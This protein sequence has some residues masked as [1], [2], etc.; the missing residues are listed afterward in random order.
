MREIGR[1]IGVQLRGGDLVV[2][3]GGLGAGKT[4][5]A[6][7]IGSALGITNVTSPTFV[8]SRIHNGKI[9]LIHVDAYRLIPSKQRDFEFD[10]LDIEMNRSEAITVIE[11]GSDVAIRLSDEYLT[12]NI[13]FGERENERIITFSG[14][15]KRW[16]NFSL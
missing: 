4:A 8:I 13:E 12:I 9:P 2:L 16:E 5:L 1:K 3:S 11:W 14:V 6:Q 15:G 10:D 7:G